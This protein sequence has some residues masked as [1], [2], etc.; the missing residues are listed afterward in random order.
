MFA[1]AHAYSD[2]NSSTLSACGETEISLWQ[3]TCA[4]L[5][6]A[7]PRSPRNYTRRWKF[8]VSVSLSP[9][10]SDQCLGLTPLRNSNVQCGYVPT[11]LEALDKFVDMW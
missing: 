5:K 6:H 4:E 7:M 11:T 2:V 10:D 3:S 9:T 8:Q 1:K